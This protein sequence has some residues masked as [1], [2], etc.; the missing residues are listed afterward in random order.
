MTYS[1]T[2]KLSSFATRKRLA[3]AAGWTN[4]RVYEDS[5]GPSILI[6]DPGPHDVVKAKVTGHVPDY[7]EEPAAVTGLERALVSDADYAT[8]MCFLQEECASHA[9]WDDP[10]I[11]PVARLSRHECATA[12]ERVAALLRLLDCR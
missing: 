5:A 1:A 11:R 7:A 2:I 10:L 3:I 9:G 4:I 8:Y 12:R 6:G